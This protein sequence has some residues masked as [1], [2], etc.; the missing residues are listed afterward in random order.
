MKQTEKM[1][2]W[3]LQVAIRKEIARKTNLLKKI[4]LMIIHQTKQGMHNV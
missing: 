2:L 3:T 4:E 1:N